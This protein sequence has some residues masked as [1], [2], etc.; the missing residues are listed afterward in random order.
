MRRI[1][2]SSI[3]LACIAALPTTARSAGAM[4]FPDGSYRFPYGGM[5]RPAIHVQTG[6]HCDI[7]LQNGEKIH[8]VFISDSSRWKVS[9]G[10]SGPDVAHVVVKPTEPNLSTALTIMTNRRAYHVD[11]VSTKKTGAEFVGFYY[12]PTMEQL[13]AQAAVRSAALRRARKLARRPPPKPTHPPQYACTTLDGAYTMRGTDA[14][15]PTSV[16]NDGRHTYV[17]IPEPS[18]DLPILKQVGGD[19]KDARATYT[20]DNAHNE[21]TVD[22]TPN[23]LVLVR[24][25][26]RL[27]LARD[28][29]KNTAATSTAQAGHR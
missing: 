17:N 5:E 18:G 16:C 9:T 23:Q 2:V 25:R 11:L 15:R 24:G 7:A 1:L 14:L 6:V 27:V 10:W 26:D 3:L 19:G 28:R 4:L 8:D 12:P 29:S 22:G 13:R 20:F 21:Y